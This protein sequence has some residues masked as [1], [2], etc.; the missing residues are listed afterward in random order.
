ME[1][2]IT[3]SFDYEQKTPF[4]KIY[5]KGSDDERD[6]MVRAFL[7][8]IPS[9]VSFVKFQYEDHSREDG[10]Q[11][12]GIRPITFDNLP[13]ELKTMKA[14]VDYVQAKTLPKQV[15]QYVS[16]TSKGFLIFL[17]ERGIYHETDL[18]KGATGI[19]GK[20]DLFNLGVEWGQYSTKLCSQ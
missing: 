15:L 16:E 1:S 17:E 13:E 11:V 12:V 9:D 19:S 2:K 4:I 20:V 7:S 10:A 18:S 3:I 8:S 6:K 5:Y 14:W